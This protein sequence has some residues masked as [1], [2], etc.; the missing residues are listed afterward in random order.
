MPY[1][2]LCIVLDRVAAKILANTVRP[3]GAGAPESKPPQA[4][5]PDGPG[6]QQP[7]GQAGQGG[8]RRPSGRTAKPAGG[9]QRP[10]GLHSRRACPAEAPWKTREPPPEPQD[11]ILQDMLAI[12]RHSCDVPVT[13]KTCHVFFT[14]LACETWVVGGTRHGSDFDPIVGTHHA[15]DFQDGPAW[16]QTLFPA[17]GSVPGPPPGRLDR[18]ASSPV[19]GPSIEVEIPPGISSEIFTATS[20]AIGMP[21]GF[22][23]KSRP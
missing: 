12:T 23:T 11:A 4:T 3:C 9:A 6:A 2:D 1:S 18:L 8:D 10:R 19:R 22:S 16:P 13:V 21:P 5:R 14:M 7:H 20:L 17:L 15:Q